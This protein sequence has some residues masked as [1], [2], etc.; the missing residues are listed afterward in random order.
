MTQ[1]QIMKR[2]IR[3]FLLSIVAYALILIASIL[4]IQNIEMAKP[5]Q[6]IVTLAPV[7]PVAFVLVVILRLLRESDELQQRVNMLAITFSAVLTGLLTFSYGFL[8]NIG[9]PKL[10]T[11][12]IFPMLFVLWG[13]GLGYFTRR[14]Q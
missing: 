11:F 6:V 14:Y 2:Y 3:E 8:E 13:I 10:P 1:K 9:F 5:L 4:A 12:A 7:I